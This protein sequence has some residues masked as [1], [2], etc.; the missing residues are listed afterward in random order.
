MAT[1]TVTASPSKVDSKKEALAASP[2]KD[3]DGAESAGAKSKTLSEAQKNI[4][5]FRT[6]EGLSRASFYDLLKDRP[7]MKPFKLGI[8]RCMNM[9]HMEEIHEEALAIETVEA[10]HAFQDKWEDSVECAGDLMNAVCQA[11]GDVAGHIKATE[12]TRVRKQKAEEIQKEKDELKKIRGAAALAAAA[13]K[14]KAGKVVGPAIFAVDFKSI[15][16]ITPVPAY[17][18]ALALESASW[19]RPFY[20]ETPDDL[21]LFFGDGK[22]TKA[23]STYAS[24]YVK[25]LQRAKGA[26]L[27]RDQSR[28]DDAD[29]HKICTDMLTDTIP[30]HDI[31]KVEGGASFMQGVYLFGFDNHPRMHYIG[32]TPSQASMVRFLFVGQV[33]TLLIKLSSLIDV[34]SGKVGPACENLEYFDSVGNWSSEKLKHLVEAGVCMY[35]HVH[36]SNQMLYIPQG[37]VVVEST[38]PGAPSHY[39]IRKAFFTRTEPAIKEYEH[40]ISLFKASAKDI[41]KANAILDS[42]KYG[43]E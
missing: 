38:L 4:G 19:E 1:P 12:R 2:E 23:L 28:I 6:V 14:Q 21:K 22:L 11:A 41:S 42:M 20:L 25:T 24:A 43:G 30:E 10:F 27:G 26:T 39:G 34:S 8:V 5:R 9:P 7:S 36:S 32:L 35:Q 18:T 16:F 17:E 15:G 3:K 40:A 29:V 13:V 37:W 33:S 31:S